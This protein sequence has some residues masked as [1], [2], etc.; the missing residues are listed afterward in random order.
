MFT[1]SEYLI[2]VLIFSMRSPSVG[3]RMMF[4]P[5]PLQ[6]PCLAGRN[7]LDLTIPN[8]I[9][10]APYIS[11]ILD[12]TPRPKV[13]ISLLVLHDAVHCSYFLFPAELYLNN[14]WRRSL[15]KK[16]I[17]VQFVTKSPVFCSTRSFITILRMTVISDFVHRPVF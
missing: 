14:P 2:F 16:L 15:L 3:I 12:F 17:V 11:S 9:G 4:L 1:Q 5:T 13:R 7:L 6:V 8:N 10:I